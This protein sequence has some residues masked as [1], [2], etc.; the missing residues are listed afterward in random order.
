MESR[1]FGPTG[2]AV[3]VIGQGTWLIDG[4]DR[5]KA[6]AALRRGLDLGMTHIDTAEM[7][8]KAEEVVAEAMSGRRDEVFLVSKVLP[9]N[10]SR[11]GTVEASARSPGCTRTTS[12]CTCCTGRAAS[13]RWRA[14]SRPS[15]SCG[16]RGRSAPGA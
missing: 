11:R 2:R 10:A 3:P 5:R 9:G 12:I 6:V 7:Y 15:S 16:T 14:P 8:G 13:I 1:P 4:D